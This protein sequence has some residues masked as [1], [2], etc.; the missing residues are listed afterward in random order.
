MGPGEFPGFVLRMEGAEEG[1]AKDVVGEVE[2]AGGGSGHLLIDPILTRVCL[3]W[4][5][6]AR[7]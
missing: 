7:G 1:G 4:L 5:G 6:F 3:E 2:L